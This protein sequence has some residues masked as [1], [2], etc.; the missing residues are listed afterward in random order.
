MI[1]ETR[2]HMLFS[3]ASVKPEVVAA[4]DRAIEALQRDGT[5]DKI[6]AKYL[7]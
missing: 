3:K 5:M 6:M 7:E 1:Y 4:F 2:L